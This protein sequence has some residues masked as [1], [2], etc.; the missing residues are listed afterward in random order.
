MRTITVVTATRAEYGLLRPVVQ[1]IAASDVLDLSLIHIFG[2]EPIFI[3]CD[4]SLC[5]DPDAV[6][7][8]CAN[9]CE[10][11]DGRLYNKAKGHCSSIILLLHFRRRDIPRVKQLRT[12]PTSMNVLR[13]RAAIQISP[14]CITER[15]RIAAILIRAQKHIR[16]V[17]RT[18]GTMPMRKIPSATKVQPILSTTT[19]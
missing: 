1:K 15:R 11:R 4:D 2:A 12:A 9:H 5:I 16:P 13:L 6:E 3:G 14:V 19:A 8:F 18:G 10:L 17:Q 7:D